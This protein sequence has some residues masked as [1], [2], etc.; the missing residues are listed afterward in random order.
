MACVL[1]FSKEKRVDLKLKN[2]SNG[3]LMGYDIPDYT[4]WLRVPFPSVSRLPLSFQ[5]QLGPDLSRQWMGRSPASSP[6]VGAPHAPAAGSST[7]PP[8]DQQR[9]L[10]ARV[11]W[12]Q[13]D[14]VGAS[15]GAAASGHMLFDSLSLPSKLRVLISP[16][17]DDS[18]SSKECHLLLEGLSFREVYL[19][20]GMSTEPADD[21]L[22]GVA[23]LESEAW[24]QRG[25]HPLDSFLLFVKNWICP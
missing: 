7:R 1:L 2:P 3:E 17:C 19:E 16:L 25:F 14:L 20:Q 22:R 5:M 15:A 23:V 8:I 18:M 4:K 13:L 24:T 12:R 21:L 11:M 10:D 6:S 9:L